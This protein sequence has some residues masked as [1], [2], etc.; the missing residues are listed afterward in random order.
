MLFQTVH[1]AHDINGLSTSCSFF[2]MNK[3]HIL[4]WHESNKMI[5]CGCESGK[6]DAN[7]LALAKNNKI[8]RQNQSIQAHTKTTFLSENRRKKG[9]E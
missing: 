5:L 1:E 8:K 9:N 3:I 4:L 2:S 6:R 7:G